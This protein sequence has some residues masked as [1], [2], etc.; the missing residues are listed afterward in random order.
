MNKVA[1]QKALELLKNNWADAII[2]SLLYSLVTS[3]LSSIG[4]G[5]ILFSVT[6]GVCYV[7]ALI[8][9]SVTQKFKIDDLFRKENFNNLT[10]QL[11]TSALSFLYI[12]LWTLCLIIPGI[13]KFYSYRLV[14]Y[15][16][17]LEPELPHSEVLKKSEE[18]MMGKK[19]DLFLFDL[20][21]IGWYILV[22][23]TFGLGMLLLTPY[24]M[25]AEV[26]YIH[27]N[28]MPLRSNQTEE[29]IFE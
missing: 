12:L 6:I 19:W 25:Q 18:L 11:A 29:N 21:F 2:I 7:Y 9:A 22:G 23:L 17:L 3:V 27:A 20:S 14:N 16:S 10:N 4:A 5:I 26:E 13:I 24:K 15:I 8:Q 28:I 1:K